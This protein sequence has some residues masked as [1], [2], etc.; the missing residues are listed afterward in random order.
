MQI[1]YQNSVFLNFLFHREDSSVTST[2]DVGVA[3]FG[4]ASI[5]KVADAAESR[6]EMAS[7]AYPDIEVV[8]GFVLYCNHI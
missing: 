7:I 8:G 4:I 1:L 6:M 2:L 5:I 3:W